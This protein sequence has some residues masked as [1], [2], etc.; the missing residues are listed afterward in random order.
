MECCSMSLT[1]SIRHCRLA[2]S[3][4]KPLGISRQGFSTPVAWTQ[5]YASRSILMR[6]TKFLCPFCAWR[7]TDYTETRPL[8]K[9]YRLC[10]QLVTACSAPTLCT[11]IT[12]FS[13]TITALYL[14][15]S[16]NTFCAWVFPLCF[17]MT[18]EAKSN[19]IVW[20]T[21]QLG[22]STPCFNVMDLQTHS[23]RSAV[24]ASIV[25]PLQHGFYKH[26]IFWLFIMALSFCPMAALP[27]M[28]SLARKISSC[29]GNSATAPISP[30]MCGGGIKHFAALGARHFNSSKRVASTCPAMFALTSHWAITGRAYIC[31]DQQRRFI[32]FN[33]QSRTA[34]FCM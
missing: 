11:F 22:V 2:A 27:V 13:A 16:I 7:C 33:T 25:I 34:I 30:K 23:I 6:N 12:G 31:F 14:Y 8:P 3:N 1:I 4:T 15:R 5:S 28:R 9:A 10:A 19:T 32:T 17:I 20:L 29:A 24:L 18:W 26:Q 21:A